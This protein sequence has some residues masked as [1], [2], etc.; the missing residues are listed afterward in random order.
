M[1]L[2]NEIVNLFTWAEDNNVTLTVRTRDLHVGDI[3][4]KLGRKGCG[5][6]LKIFSIDELNHSKVDFLP[7]VLEDMVHKLDN[8]EEVAK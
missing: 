5:E 8:N 4:I 6:V 1:R 7:I 2:T 3:V